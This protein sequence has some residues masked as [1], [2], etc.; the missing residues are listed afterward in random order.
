MSATLLGGC[1]GE[2]DVEQPYGALFVER[3]VLVAALR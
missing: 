2:K 1:V 3:M